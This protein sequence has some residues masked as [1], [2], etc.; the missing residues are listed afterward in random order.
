[1]RLVSEPEVPR[2][3]LESLRAGLAP[4]PTMLDLRASLR[5]DRALFL[6]AADL[7]E[8]LPPGTSAR[9]GLFRLLQDENDTRW[10]LRS[11]GNPETASQ[12]GSQ[13][14]RDVDHIEI[15]WQKTFLSGPAWRQWLSEDPGQGL[16]PLL[17][18]GLG[19]FLA[20]EN[21]RMNYLVALSALDARIA[22]E[23][24]G[25]EAAR[26]VPDPAR[27]GAFFQA[28]KTEGGVRL[29]SAYVPQGKT[30][31]LSFFVPTFLEKAP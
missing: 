4:A 7:L 20:F 18:K 25:L 14:R 29:S 9:A 30:D 12:V 16:S 31:A 19:G 22:L 10:Y 24:G 13:L 6:R 26:R 23:Q 15:L 21:V 8:K 11:S 2:E 1:M 3:W 17:A 27:P 28:E 5:A